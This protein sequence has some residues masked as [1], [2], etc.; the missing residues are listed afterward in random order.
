MLYLY[1]LDGNTFDAVV[2]FFSAKGLSAYTATV[3]DYR[4]AEIGFEVEDQAA[5]NDLERAIN[6][7]LLDHCK[8]NDLLD[9]FQFR[10]E[11]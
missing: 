10:Y 1:L 4:N 8:E 6:A 7:E 3:I 11:K 9:D 2:V 5:A